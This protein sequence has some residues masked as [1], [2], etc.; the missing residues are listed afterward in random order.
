MKK[1]AKKIAMSLLERVGI[2]EQAEKF[3]SA[4]WRPTTQKYKGSCNEAKN[5]VV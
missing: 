3:Q 2:P 1:K 5:Y 4:F